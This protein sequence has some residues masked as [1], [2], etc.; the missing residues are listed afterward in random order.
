MKIQLFF[1]AA[2]VLF[3]TSCST[4]IAKLSKEEMSNARIS[5]YD[6]F[7]RKND[8]SIVE[9]STADKKGLII[10][11]VSKYFKV[12]GEK[13]DYTDVNAFQT[14]KGYS[15]RVYQHTNISKNA[16]L[17]EFFANRI[18][19][20]K[21]EFFILYETKSVTSYD[22]DRKRNVTSNRTEPLYMLRKKSEQDNIRI[23]SKDLLMQMV[24][25]NAEVSKQ[26]KNMSK[27]TNTRKAIMT[28]V[29]AYN[30]Q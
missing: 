6:G 28:L 29:K 16:G 10:H 20:G 15:E 22:F 3:L 8:G 5:K 18:I 27:L 25:D 13:I 24:A 1:I 4:N 2:T 9:F 21:I 17:N 7:V 11:S 26:F 30:N 19:D 23:Y 12:N 14:K